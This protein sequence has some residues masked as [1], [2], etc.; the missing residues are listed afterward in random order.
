[1]CVALLSFNSAIIFKGGIIVDKYLMPF[2][3]KSKLP[4]RDFYSYG[5]IV[6]FVGSVLGL[7]ASIVVVAANY[8]V[9]LSALRFLGLT[10]GMCFV[11]GLMLIFVLIRWHS[12]VKELQRK[13]VEKFP[14]YATIVLKMDET[15]FYVG[16]AIA[17]AGLI[18]NFFVVFGFAVIVVGLALAY[19]FFFKSVRNFE[20][21]EIKFFSTALN[22]S[23]ERCFKFDLD[24][25]TLLYTMLTLFGYFML[26]Q[27]EYFFAIDE[28][29]KKRM[30]LPGEVKL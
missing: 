8:L 6:F 2:I 19:H 24:T 1:M 10:E 7:I 5:L 9:A 28:Y 4:S 23:L 13:A 12:V 30:E 21:E 29:V 25:N 14:N 11:S 16:I 17:A 3:D 18:I 27:E 20:E 22:K 26:H 15:L